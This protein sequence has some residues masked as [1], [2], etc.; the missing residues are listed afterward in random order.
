MARPTVSPGF[1]PGR[2]PVGHGGEGRSEGQRTA[3]AAKPSQ[4][5]PPGSEGCCPVRWPQEADRANRTLEVLFSTQTQGCGR[6][7]LRGSHLAGHQPGRCPARP[8]SALHT[9]NRHITTHVFSLYVT[10]GELEI[11]SGNLPSMSFLTSFL[12]AQPKLCPQQPPW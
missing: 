6:Q 1:R 8:K 3:Q 4:P 7:A 5:R 2:D 11:L 10:L 9:G 12:S